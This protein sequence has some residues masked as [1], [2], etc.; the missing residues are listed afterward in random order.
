MLE[1]TNNLFAGILSC[2]SGTSPA[3]ASHNAVGCIPDGRRND[4]Q[5]AC[6][7]PDSSQ[8]LHGPQYCRGLGPG[9]VGICQDDRF[10]CVLQWFD[11]NPP[12]FVVTG[13]PVDGFL[14]KGA[15]VVITENDILMH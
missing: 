4:P 11:G 9:P 13:K 3:A 1:N 12:V 2:L 10:G 8:M 15:L 6:K 7:F 14:A 5:N